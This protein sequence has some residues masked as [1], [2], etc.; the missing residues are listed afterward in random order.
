MQA[1]TR[2]S[3]ER[4]P[5]VGVI[6]LG[7]VGLPVAVA[8]GK[9]L[10][11]VVGFDI[12]ERRV[13][14]LNAGVD[15]TKEVQAQDLEE[16]GVYFSTN[17]RSLVGCDFYIV[18]V[19]TPIDATRKPDL[20][21]LKLASETVGSVMRSGAI[22][23]YESTVYPGVT[24]EVCGP[25]LEEASGLRCGVDFKL[26]YSP[27]RINP[28][29]KVH[30]LETITK[31]VS[32]QDEDA[33]AD[34]AGLYEQIVNA[35]VHRASSIRV[36]EAAKVIENTQRDLNIALMNEL[37]VVFDRLE[38]DTQEV[39]AAAKT[40]WNF[41]PFHPGLVGGHCIGVDP[42]YLTSKAEQAGVHPQVILAGRRTNDGMA[43]FVVERTVKELIAARKPIRGS[44]VAVVGVTFKEN[45]PD[46]RNSR[47]PEIC[48]GLEEYGVEVLVFDPYADPNEVAGEYGLKLG[49]LSQ[50]EGSDAVLFAVPHD[51][52][53]ESVTAMLAHENTAVLVD[54]KGA[55][56]KSS[57]P[58]GVRYWRL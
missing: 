7:Y 49:E 57:V 15:V 5:K 20:R 2:V 18:T 37:S 22:V 25:I 26:G 21:A 32:G 40:K 45:V 35:G 6:G 1:A 12:S 54:V 50:L 39:L 56:A 11:D 47:V 3:Q 14:Q 27:E 19:P 53:S 48:K 8:F 23:V 36:A 44:R 30:R 29:D 43:S 58:N 17:P 34:I 51:G 28:G 41:L 42:Y 38:I 31:V 9:K 4:I 33:L 52:L 46:V 13:K 55:V 10:G 24:E 16:C